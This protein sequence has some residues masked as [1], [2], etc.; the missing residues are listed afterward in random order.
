MTPLELLSRAEATLLTAQSTV[1]W[2][3]IEDIRH[4]RAQLEHTQT[5]LVVCVQTATARHR[6]ATLRPLNALTRSAT[7]ARRGSVSATTTTTMPARV[8]AYLHVE[9]MAARSRVSGPVR[10]YRDLPLRF[11]AWAH[12]I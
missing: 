8:M 12:S 2:Q 1:G 10:R 6:R 4:A 3:A 9:L 11:A 5:L 7:L